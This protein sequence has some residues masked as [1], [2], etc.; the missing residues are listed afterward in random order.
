MLM[1][2]IF[3]KIYA[4]KLHNMDM[5]RVVNIFL[6]DKTLQEFPVEGKDFPVGGK[7]RE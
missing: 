1:D 4:S 5:G 7:D 2:S 6:T 3:R